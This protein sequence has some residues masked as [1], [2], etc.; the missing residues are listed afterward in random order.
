MFPIVRG[1][2]KEKRKGKRII[3]SALGTYGEFA[4][5]KTC[6]YSKER[7]KTLRQHQW[8]GL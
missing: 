3:V 4:V 2:E 6:C 8:P 7:G 5:C 1:Q